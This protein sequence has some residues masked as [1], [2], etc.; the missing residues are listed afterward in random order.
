MT[1]IKKIITL[2]VLFFLFDIAASIPLS[3]LVKS[4]NIRYSRLYNDKIDADVIFMGNSK[5]INSFY[6]PYFN[7]ISQLKSINLS[8]NGLGLKLVKIFLD[9]YLK[10]NAPPEIIFIEMSCFNEDLEVLPNFKQYISESPALNNLFKEQLPLN[11]FISKL[12][13][14]FKYNSEYFLR[15]LY[16]L[17]N[18]DQTWINRY[19]ITDDY[20]N[21]LDEDFNALSTQ[22]L[23]KPIVE[24]FH[25]MLSTYSSLQIKIIPVIAP[26][27]DKHRNE[28]AIRNYIVEFENIFPVKILDLSGAVTNINMFADQYHTNEQGAIIIAE[29]L[30][31]LPEIKELQSNA[32]E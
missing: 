7:E 9:D 18:N 12:S 8:Y 19:S 32:R 10:R 28:P 14:S 29:E 21:N 17:K 13:A 1:L 30:I 26:I 22:E 20:Y 31:K 15:T 11:Y 3:I 16:Y 6:S 27:I 4:S 5:A 23:T 25:E 2:F 24:L